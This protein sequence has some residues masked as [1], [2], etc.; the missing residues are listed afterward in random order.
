MPQIRKRGRPSESLKKEQGGQPYKRFLGIMQRTVK[1]VC[2]FLGEV[3][4]A[5]E[6]AEL[7]SIDCLLTVLLTVY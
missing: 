3:P 1:E 2:R 6:G 7:V 5:A 4:G